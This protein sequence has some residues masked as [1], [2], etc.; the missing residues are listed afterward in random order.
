MPRTC[1]MNTTLKD[2]LDLTV[3]NGIHRIWIVDAQKKPLAVLSLTEII[4]KVISSV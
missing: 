1:D 3:D 4:A 2:V